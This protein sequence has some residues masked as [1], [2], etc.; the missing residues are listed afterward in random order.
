MN[1]EHGYTLVEAAVTFVLLGVIGVIVC[2][3]AQQILAVPDRGN[4]HV[5]ALHDLQNTA[6]W[7]AEDVQEAKSA[8]G[9]SS[10]TLTMP[11]NSTI[12]YTRVGSTLSRTYGEQTINIAGSITS[13]SFTVTSRSISMAITAHP[14]SRWNI[15]ETKTYQFIMRVNA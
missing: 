9:G 13:L 2:M 6:H 10:L 1:R 15:T 12:S 3:A 4:D 11:D 14:A 8:V 5:T 7:L